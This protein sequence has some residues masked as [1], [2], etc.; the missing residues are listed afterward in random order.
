VGLAVPLVV[1]VL[2]AVSEEA[3]LEVREQ[4]PAINAVDPIISLVTARLRQ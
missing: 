2:A 4:L 1:E 3:S